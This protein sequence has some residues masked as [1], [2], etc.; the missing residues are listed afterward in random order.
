MTAMLPRKILNSAVRR[1]IWEP[2]KNKSG[3][4][5]SQEMFLILGQPQT[6]VS[7]VLFHGTRGNGKSACLLMGYAQHVGKG[8]GPYWNGIILR[9]QYS[10]LRDLI[11]ESRK[12]FPRLFPGAKYKKGEKTWI[13]PT[14]EELLF[15]YAEKEEHYQAKLHGQQ[16][17]YIGV[18][19]LTTWA[20]DDIY[21]KL[22]STL[23]TAYKPTDHQPLMPPLQIRAMT[24]P[25]GVGKRWV[26]ERFIDGKRNGEIE[27]TRQ[28]LLDENDKEIVVEWSRCAIFGT[29][30]EN[31]YV[32]VRYKAWLMSLADPILREAWLYGN[33]EVVDDTAMFAQVWDR[34]VHILQPFDIPAAWKV[35]RSFDYGQS[36]PFCC[37][38]TAE[39]NGEAVT[40]GGKVFCPPKGSLI[41][42]GEDYGTPLTSD[43][44]QQK[45]DLGLFLS[46]GKI[47]ARLKVRELKLQA[48]VLK[49]HSSIDAGPAD[50]QIFNGSKVDNGTAPTVA[51]E[52]EKE[53][54]TFS[55]SDK[56][57]GSRIT[58]AQIMF[59]R[60]QATADRNPEKPHIYIFS[61]CKFLTRTIP[62]LYRDEDEPDSVAK[63]ADDHSWDALAYRLTWKRPHTA[64]K[65]GIMY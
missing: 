20:S 18:D 37:L 8:W 5:S 3:G 14:G 44:K 61:G 1:V 26:K 6:L 27:R 52:L 21:I 36:T 28:T 46:A 42:C 12:I 25:W 4:L 17:A 48:T 7:E 10:A 63:G 53:G 65:H 19:E 60:L 51:K 58:S 41:I 33:W 45:R 39:A 55:Q 34:D 29:V 40:I 30:F 54:I 38:W 16:Y 57:A 62:D 49:N 35:D 32:D 64:V 23:R 31:S 2:T 15:Q 50:N 24:N 22:L 13:F 59:E 9:R 47:G 43:G 56:R 11:I